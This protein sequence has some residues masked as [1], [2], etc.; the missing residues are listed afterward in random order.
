[1][2]IFGLALMGA[3][4]AAEEVPLPERI[5][6][7]FVAFGLLSIA[8]V[9]FTRASRSRERDIK[10]LRRATRRCEWREDV[11]IGALRDHGVTVPPE[12][13][14]GPPDEDD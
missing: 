11:L 4:L 1:M 6:T 7:G 10:E 2:A 8:L 13:W 12:Y 9:V 3:V 5:G 14:R